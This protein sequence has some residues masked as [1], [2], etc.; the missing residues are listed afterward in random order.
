M[1]LVLRCPY[2]SWTS[3]YVDLACNE[4]VGM[5]IS[6]SDKNILT[7]SVQF[8]D[9]ILRV[10]MRAVGAANRAVNDGGKT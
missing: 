5:L 3:N 10:G 1:G 2:I 9:Q 7:G 6:D 4:E 8:V